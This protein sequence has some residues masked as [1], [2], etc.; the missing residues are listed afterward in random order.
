MTM[1]HSKAPPPLHCSSPHTHNIYTAYKEM[2]H[3]KEICNCICMQHPTRE[4]SFCK[5]DKFGSVVTAFNYVSCFNASL[6]RY[7]ML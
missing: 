1:L 2:S 7:T 6:S 5:N 3:K 4:N